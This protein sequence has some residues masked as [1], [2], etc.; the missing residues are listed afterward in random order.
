MRANTDKANI[1]AF[2]VAL[3]NRLK[4]ELDINVEL[5]SPDHFIPAVPGWRDR[6]L[7]IGQEGRI[8]FFHYDP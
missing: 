4:D 6:S 5:A 8:R 1:R 7:L 3:G 2:M